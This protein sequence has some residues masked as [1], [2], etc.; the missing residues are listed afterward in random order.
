MLDGKV[1]TPNFLPPSHFA[2][3][4]KM[5][6]YASNNQHYVK[7][8]RKLWLVLL[9]L[10]LLLYVSGHFHIQKKVASFHTQK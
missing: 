5:R 2:V 9:I 4:W 8:K 10:Y 7:V 3:G 6:K 1:L